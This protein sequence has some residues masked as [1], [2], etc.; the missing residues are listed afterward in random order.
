MNNDRYGVLLK[1]PFSLALHCDYTISNTYKLKTRVELRTQKLEVPS[2][3]LEEIM[4][5]NVPILLYKSLYK[6]N[7]HG[8]DVGV[9][10][11]LRWDIV[12]KNNKSSLDNVGL[13]NGNIAYL[14]TVNNFLKPNILANFGFCFQKQMN[15]NSSLQV[16]LHYIKSIQNLDYVSID[17]RKLIYEDNEIKGY[18]TYHDIINLSINAIQCG[19]YIGFGR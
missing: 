17:T 11:G 10:G 13:N 15:I 16:Y 2:I 8:W 1:L 3:F 12:L 5:I 4:R 7:K 18:N 9:E 6:N 19:I 14:R